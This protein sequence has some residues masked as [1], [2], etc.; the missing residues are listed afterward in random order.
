M[1][2][3]LLCCCVVLLYVNVS[4]QSPLIETGVSYSLAAY[5]KNIIKQIHYSL[6]L[7]VPENKVQNIGAT[8]TLTFSLKKDNDNPLQIDFKS[9]S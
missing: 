9:D 8:E 5:R 6:H 1:K 4:A 2:K 7:S 3:I